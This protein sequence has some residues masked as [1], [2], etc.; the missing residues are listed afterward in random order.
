MNT[1]I[2]ILLALIAQNVFAAGEHK[3]HKHH[4]AAHVHGGGELSIAFDN[5][6]GRIEFKTA[7]QS[8]LGFEYK[9]KKDK[10]LQK[11]KTVT[12]QFNNSIQQFVQFDQGAECIITPDVIGQ[13]PEKGETEIVKHSDWQAHYNVVCKKSVVDTKIKIDFSV[14]KNLK[15]LDVTVLAGSLQK[16]VEYKGKPIEINLK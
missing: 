11:L 1:K 12:E 4:H 7:A 8:V 14:F 15:D 9:P 13:I 3:H 5:L 6:N 10:D 16:S 2:I